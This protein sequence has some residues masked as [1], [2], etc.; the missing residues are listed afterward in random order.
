MLKRF[1]CLMI[2]II[3]FLNLIF[4]ILSIA[5]DEIV[6]IKFEDEKLYNAIVENIGKKIANNDDSTYTIQITRE[7]LESITSLSFTAKGI[8]NISGIENFGYLEGLSFWNEKIED[9]SPI[10]NLVNLKSLSIDYNSP[11]IE[12][13]NFLNKLVQLTSL[14]ICADS[15]NRGTARGNTIKDISALQNMSNLKSL[16]L[17]QNE[18]SDITPLR[19]LSGLTSLNLE[20]SPIEDVSI[21]CN[22]NNLKTLHLE[23]CEI[24]DNDLEYICNLTNLTSLYLG[25]INYEYNN[26]NNIE[27]IKKLTNLTT[28]RLDNNNITDITALS[29]LV[30]LE[31]LAL[32]G[33]NISN[34]EPL[35][36]LTKL[37]TLNLG[38]DNYGTGNPISTIKPLENL[39]N[40]TELNI[41]MCN[42]SDISSLASMNKLSTLDLMCNEIKDISSLSGLT[43][44]TSLQLWGNKIND[45]SSLANLTKLTSLDIGYNEIMDLSILEQMEINSLIFNS[46]K[47]TINVKNDG[48]IELPN[49][50][51]QAKDP[52][53]RIYTDKEWKFT[54]CALSED[55]KYIILE[56]KNSNAKV[57]IGGERYSTNKTHVLDKDARYITLE[58]LVEDTIPPILDVKYS[59]KKMTKETVTATI[60]ANEKIQQVEGWVLSE[61]ETKL[62]K[63][64][65]K[66]T[67]ETITVY[68]LAGNK[69]YANIS[70]N[71]ID[72]T[73]P[74]VEIKYSTTKLT[75]QNVT[76]TVTADEKIKEVEGWILSNDKTTLSKDFE[77]NQEEDITIYD[78]VGND[79]KLT[80]NVSNIDKTPPIA[81]I[82]Y[83]TLELTNGNVEV[84]ITADEEIQE[85][86][87]WI[88]SS[89]RKKL[90][91]EY[92]KNI[93]KEKVIINDLAGNSTEK[94][95]TI[96]NID[97]IPPELEI[98]YSTIEKTNGTVI[99][100]IKANEK[101]KEVEGWTLNE[102]QNTLTR[103]FD[104]NTTEQIIVYDLVGNGTAQEININNIKDKTIFTQTEDKTVAPTILPQT[105]EDFIIVIIGIF[106]TMLISMIMYKKYKNYKDIK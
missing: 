54:N 95:I 63:V 25:N 38:R 98:I 36:N 96:A 27:P 26:I 67:E 37:K 87:G 76:V 34:L 97:K 11:K 82:S 79:R 52:N 44:L 94:E 28:L 8:T 17:A 102:E 78:L 71:N 23:S 43:N 100:Q 104:E 69:A 20:G 4:P 64:Y 41:A 89:D 83:S 1:T 15:Y 77:S 80:I 5:T 61:D 99:V 12:N 75:N 39:T 86:D 90:G 53:S 65:A 30:N 48:K 16:L 3:F 103:E 55:G 45:I 9:F 72:T 62:S 66:N 101:V 47:L 58:I 92:E 50:F 81:K 106:T 59:T 10:E 22:L 74:Q 60:T 73:S 93:E 105:G 14:S 7:N 40:L 31:N 84:I 85:I 68:D 24:D 19:S 29:D 88:M 51:L 32:R 35:S 21:L 18:I 91:K 6:T 13:I 33:N 57:T 56:N 70:V 49:I 42:I 2:L 46:Q